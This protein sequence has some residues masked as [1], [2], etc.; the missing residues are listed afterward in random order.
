[1][2]LPAEIAGSDE[3][4]QNEI[5]NVAVHVAVGEWNDRLFPKA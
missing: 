4:K 2:A 5:Y 3:K 1:M